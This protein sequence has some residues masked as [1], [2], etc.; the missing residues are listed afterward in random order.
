VS[1]LIDFFKVD[2]ENQQQHIYAH[3]EFFTLKAGQPARSKVKQNFEILKTLR[4]ESVLLSKYMK[5]TYNIDLPI[6][7]KSGC[8]MQFPF[9]N[10]W[11]RG[12]EYGFLC[13][14]YY[15]YTNIFKKF[16]IAECEHPD[17][18]YSNP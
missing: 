13:R 4:E 14:H 18:I 7:S 11:L 9:R 5:K 3:K 1:N 15:A 10:R 12:E 8:I 16:E 2:F 17:S 6:D